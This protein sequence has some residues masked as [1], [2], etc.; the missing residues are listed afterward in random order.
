MVEARLQICCAGGT[1]KCEWLEMSHKVEE[2]EGKVGAK[3]I[4][5]LRLC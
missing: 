1:S 2:V 5:W 4:W 3:S